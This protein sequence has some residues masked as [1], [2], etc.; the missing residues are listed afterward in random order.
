MQT[1]LMAVIL[2]AA[3]SA[4]LAADELTLHIQRDED[5]NDRYL[6]LDFKNVSGNTLEMELPVEGCALCDRYFQVEAER[7]DG[8]PVRRDPK[9]AP[10]LP[11]YVVRLAPGGLYEHRIHPPANIN[12]RDTNPLTK[13]KVA[14]A[15]LN[16]GPAPWMAR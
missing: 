10:L 11:P 6:R 7:L 1:L 8:V 3:G 14:S 4:A 15:W 2:A 5:R 16:L 9:Y 13:K 12:V